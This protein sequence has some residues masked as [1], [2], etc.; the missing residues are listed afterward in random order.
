[1]RAKRNRSNPA[2][3]RT[4]PHPDY[5][6]PTREDAPTSGTVPYMNNKDG[7]LL[8]GNKENY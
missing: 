8:P 7:G 5:G 1:M 3:F 2:N 6:D 4:A